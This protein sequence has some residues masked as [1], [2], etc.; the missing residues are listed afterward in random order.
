MG[1]T[2]IVAAVGGGLD[3]FPSDSVSFRSATSGRFG[4]HLGKQ[5]SNFI[6]RHAF[7]TNH[8]LLGCVAV[9]LAATSTNLA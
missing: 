2:A 4:L 8:I 5:C 3:R 9:T 1:I 7:S 6:D